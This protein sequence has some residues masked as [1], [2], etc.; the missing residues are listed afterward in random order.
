MCPFSVK[1]YFHFHFYFPY[2]SDGTQP[3]YSTYVSVF[4]TRNELRLVNRAL[5]FRFTGQVMSGVPNATECDRL[6]DA[7]EDKVITSK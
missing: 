7:V 5:L 3:P 2:H 6:G 4:Q 1:T